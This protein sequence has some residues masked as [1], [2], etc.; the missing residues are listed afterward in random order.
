MDHALDNRLD[1]RLDNK[2]RRHT[3]VLFGVTCVLAVLASPLFVLY[4]LLLGALGLV[5]TGVLARHREG[6]GARAATVVFAGL[7][8]GSLPYLAL[9]P[10]V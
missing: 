4:E 1:N 7:L 9:A 6:P 10:F 3:L 5:A 8:A 2:S